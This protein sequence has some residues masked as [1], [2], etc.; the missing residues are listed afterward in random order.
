MLELYQFESCPFCARVR[1]KLT[2][3]ELDWIARTVPPPMSRRER[4]VKIS[5]QPLVPVLVDRD[6]R[7]IVTESH[8]IC[9]YLD[10][11]YGP[12]D[13]KTPAP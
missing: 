9:D 3:L 13:G 11:H 1:Q 12:G 10:E 7:M 5:R 6:R 8:D 2:E 4:V